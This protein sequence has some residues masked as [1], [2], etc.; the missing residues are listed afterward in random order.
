MSDKSKFVNRTLIRVISYTIQLFV[1]V[2]IFFINS[3]SI[4]QV[5]QDVQFRV[6]FVA[7]SISVRL[8][9]PPGIQ[10][11]DGCHSFVIPAKL[12]KI[13]PLMITNQPICGALIWICPNVDVYLS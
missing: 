8:Q 6:C 12:V 4:A 13:M 2:S 11:V 1:S 10:S 3:L 9:F 5:A 7:P